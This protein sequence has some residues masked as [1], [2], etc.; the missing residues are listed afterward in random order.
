MFKRIISFLSR[1][2]TC[3]LLFIPQLILVG[4]IFV[5]LNYLGFP[6]W[7][8]ALIAIFTAVFDKLGSLVYI[9][10]WVWSFII[11]VKSPFN[12]YSVIYLAFLF[13]YLFLMALSFKKARQRK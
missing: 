4:F 5:P 10:V 7:V 3:A 9:I 2:G 1:A 8:D 11:F 13:L 12:A 6:W